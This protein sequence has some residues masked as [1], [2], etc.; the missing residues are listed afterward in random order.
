M[1]TL[2]PF[3]SGLLPVALNGATKLIQYFKWSNTKTYLFTIQFGIKTN[4]GDITG[5]V[6][7]NSNIIPNTND[8]NEVL[9]KFIG[10]I[11]QKPHVF[12]AVKI[13]GKKS[14]EL[15][16][17]GIIPNIKSKKITI[18]SLKLI[19]QISND[20]YLFEANVSS[21]T[22][23]RSLSEDIAK[24]LGT[25]GCTISL[26]RTSI[27]K[28]NISNSITLDY[29]RENVHNISELVASAEDLLDDI[30][31]VTVSDEI[32]YNLSLGKSIQVTN[33]IITNNNDITTSNNIDLCL[34]KSQG[35]F[36]ELVTIYNNYMYPKKLIRN[37][38]GKDVG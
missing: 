38:G 33:Q 14:Y 35:G 8:I 37:L 31:V 29:L 20:K 13:N 24:E 11:D 18:H 6:I 17:N 4:T 16:R 5:T 21:G 25:I 32:A 10:E 36:L 26:R 22:Y 3:A 1:G 7:E 28:F 2:D 15:A 34:V 9:H 12:S 27:G 30:P 23:I 19:K